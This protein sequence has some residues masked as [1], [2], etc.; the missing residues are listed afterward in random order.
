MNED[1]AK[2]QGAWSIVALEVDGAAMPENSVRGS[3]IV[4]KGS[5]FDTIS[6][7]ATYKGKLKIDPAKNPRT[8]DL[9]FEAGPEKGNRALAIYELDGDAWRICMTVTAKTR[10]SA[11]ATTPGSGLALETLK[12]G[13]AAA[14]PL[15]AELALLEGD[16]SMV[17]C[18]RDGHSLHKAM[19]KTARRVARGNE[20]TVSFGD[21]I[22]L[23]AAYSLGLSNRPK[24]IDYILTAGPNQGAMQHGIY[25]LAGNTVRFHFAAVGQP[26]PADFVAAA[27]TGGTLTV[28]KRLK[29]TT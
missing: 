6:M 13:A 3:Q 20:T 23:K 26:R 12:R 25:E 15:R 8:L 2:L 28:W 14:D 4:V 29:K 9:I 19:I 5:S 1:L 7:G 11:F 17:S 18:E 16:W 10:P 21:E 27:C 22:I 24:T